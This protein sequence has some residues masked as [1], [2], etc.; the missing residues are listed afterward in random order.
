MLKRLKE[1]PAFWEFR[2][3]AEDHAKLKLNRSDQ[4]AIVW[5][6]VHPHDG[7]ATNEHGNGAACPVIFLL[8]KHPTCMEG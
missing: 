5:P 2:V 6:Q 3:Q 7:Q 4:S 1:L 8:A